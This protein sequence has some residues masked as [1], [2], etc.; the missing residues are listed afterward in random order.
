MWHLIHR[1]FPVLSLGLLSTVFRRIKGARGCLVMACGGLNDVRSWRH[2][3][4]TI[5]PGQP[6]CPRGG[7]MRYGCSTGASTGGMLSGVSGV[8]VTVPGRRAASEVIQFK[9]MGSSPARWPTRHLR[10]FAGRRTNTAIRRHRQKF[11]PP[12]SGVVVLRYFLNE[13]GLSICTVGLD[14]MRAI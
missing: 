1:M 5:L 11:W 12:T 9:L 7:S 13:R 10:A 2:L 4:D 6:V 3:S 14:Y 8:C